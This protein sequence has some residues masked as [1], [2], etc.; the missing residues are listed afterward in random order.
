MRDSAKILGRNIFEPFVPS[1]YMTNTFPSQFF[2]A[3]FED[4]P[5]LL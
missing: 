1:S 3:L 5:K 2:S 4:A